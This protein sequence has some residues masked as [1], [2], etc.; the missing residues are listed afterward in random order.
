M[1]SDDIE[2]PEKEDDKALKRILKEV[3]DRINIIKVWLGMTKFTRYKGE[4][5]SNRRLVN[6]LDLFIKYPTHCDV[7][8]RVVFDVPPDK[9]KSNASDEA[10]LKYQSEREEHINQL[11][12]F[13]NLLLDRDVSGIKSCSIYK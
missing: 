4:K 12:E 11:R 10:I 2:I 8:Y 5:D 1:Y 9:P 6:E 3:W 7:I 13:Q